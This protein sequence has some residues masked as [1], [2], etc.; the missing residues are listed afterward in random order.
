MGVKNWV[1]SYEW[2][3]LSDENW[4]A[5]QALKLLPEMR[6]MSFQCL[7]PPIGIR[8][9]TPDWHATPAIPKSSQQFPH[10]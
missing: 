8:R 3:K 9:E 6:T 1:M 4:L 7:P 2:W 10:G 5:K